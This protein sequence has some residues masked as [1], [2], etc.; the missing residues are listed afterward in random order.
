MSDMI[1]SSLLDFVED[2]EL[3]PGE[4]EY[5][6]V[7]RAD[8]TVLQLPNVHTEPTRGFEIDPRAFLEQ[9][10]AGAV[11]TWH[12]HPAADPNLSEEDM[13]GFRQWP[14]LLHHIVGIRDGEKTVV[15]FKVLE[16]GIVVK[17]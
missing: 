1:V 15:T 17:V 5:C 6:G 2:D 10:E 9:L 12:T 8:G 13:N 4:P 7:I 14:Q 16:G 11:A 3:R